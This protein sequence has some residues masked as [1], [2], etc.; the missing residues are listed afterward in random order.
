ML[1]L[2]VN[3]QTSSNESSKGEAKD[4]FVYGNW[5]GAIEEYTTLLTQEPNNPTYL[6]R[7][8]IS[9][10]E[11]F[12]KRAF[13]IKHLEAAIKAK[14]TEKDVHFM[15][16]KAY[17]RDHQFD[18]AIKKYEAALTH[19]DNHALTMRAKLYIEMC[20]TAKKMVKH[21]LKN[22][23]IKN[24]GPS[25]NSPS[26]DYGPY[27]DEHESALYFTSTRQKGN[28]GYLNWNGRYTKDIFLSKEKNSHWY[29]AK[30]IGGNIGTS[31]DEEIVGLSVDGLDLFTNFTEA[32][33]KNDLQHAIKKGKQFSKNKSFSEDLNVPGTTELSGCLSEDKNTLYFA[34]DRAGKGGLDIFYS[35]KLP[36]GTWG[37]ETPLE[38][39]NT[40]WDDAYPHLLSGDSVLYIASEGLGSMGGFDIFKF[41]LNK[42]TNK[43]ENPQNIGYPINTVDD[44]FHLAIGKTGRTGYFSAFDPKDSTEGC[45][46]LDLYQVTFLDIKPRV[47][48]VVGSLYEEAPIDYNSY[49]EFYLMSDDSGKTTKRFPPEY[50]PPTDSIWAHIEKKKTVVKPGF[51]YVFAIT[52]EKQGEQKSFN[53]KKLPEDLDTWRFISVKTNL[54]PDKTY[55]KPSKNAPKFEEKPIKDAFVEILYKETGDLYGEYQLSPKSGNFVFPLTEG[56]DFIAH[57][58]ADGFKE[59]SIEFAAPSLASYKEYTTQKFKLKRIK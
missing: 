38:E 27:V 30:S 9:Y 20:H 41:T 7:L 5:K 39:V 22:I 34:S 8:G 14:C 12:D 33:T 44:N 40:P 2:G 32:K 59:A 26:L 18:K 24:M 43:W 37:L 54:I 55:K 57:I 29:K 51:K 4:N 47:S 46:E 11:T 16:A 6:Y 48:T 58:K 21:P 28:G 25:I 13:A 36:D 10:L 52:L 31:H 49:Q 23:Q 53:S 1:S 42:K 35:R 19:S 45:G 15:L 3:A 17:H 50:Q 56:K